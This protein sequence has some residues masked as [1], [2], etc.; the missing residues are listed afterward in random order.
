MTPSRALR[1]VE[2]VVMRPYCCPVDRVIA[3]G[4]ALFVTCSTSALKRSRLCRPNI[5]RESDDK[6]APRLAMHALEKPLKIDRPVV[7]H[8]GGR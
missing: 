6:Q 7:N 2:I 5:S 4:E 3:Y 8:G 1:G